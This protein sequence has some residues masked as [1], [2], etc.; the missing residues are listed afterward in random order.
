MLADYLKENN[1]QYRNEWSD[2]GWVYR[3]V[4]GNKVEVHNE[5]LTKFKAK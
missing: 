3:F 5:L 4:I 2:A 1:V